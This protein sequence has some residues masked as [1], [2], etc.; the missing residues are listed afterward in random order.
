MRGLPARALREGRSAPEAE[1]MGVAFARAA[2]RECQWEGF[3]S[4]APSLRYPARADRA[5]PHRIRDSSAARP[6]LAIPTRSRQ[7]QPD[8]P[9]RA[10]CAFRPRIAQYRS[11]RLNKQ[12]HDGIQERGQWT[13]SPTR[14]KIEDMSDNITNLTDDTFASSLSAPGEPMLVDFWAPWCGP[15]RMVAPVLEALAEQY[16]GRL[17]IA[18]VNVDDSPRIAESFRVSSIPT[19]I[20]FKGGQAVDQIIGARP[21]A[22]IQ[23]LIDKHLAA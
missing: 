20:L 8:P 14:A 11:G 22:D 12:P 13:Q 3:P 16:R 18:K 9:K 4:L 19:L 2:L 17:R 7:S 5:C 23:S 15:C 10:P 6:S 1:D 21:K